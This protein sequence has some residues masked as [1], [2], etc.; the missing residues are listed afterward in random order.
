MTGT[1]YPFSEYSSETGQKVKVYHSQP[2]SICADGEALD[3]HRLHV[4]IADF[5]KGEG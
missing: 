2:L 5:G 1:G 4:K 3:I